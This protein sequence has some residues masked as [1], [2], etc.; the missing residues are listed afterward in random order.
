MPST[1]SSGIDAR[2][3]LV[4]S[5]QSLPR[6][7]FQSV[8][9]AALIKALPVFLHVLQKF[10]LHHCGHYLGFFFFIISRCHRQTDTHIWFQC[11]YLCFHLCYL[12]FLGCFPYAVSVLTGTINVSARQT[13]FFYLAQDYSEVISTINCILF[14][15]S[16]YNYFSVLVVSI[17]C[18]LFYFGFTVNRFHN[19]RIQFNPINKTNC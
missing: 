17:I 3:I 19:R 15:L 4:L 10:W 5:K 12:W 2:F 6:P 7:F 18:F 16:C 8:K 13:C 11:S 14:F 1:T 9:M